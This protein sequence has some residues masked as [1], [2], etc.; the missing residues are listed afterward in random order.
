[1]PTTNQQEPPA[2]PAYGLKRPTFGLSREK[3][4]RVELILAVRGG[5]VITL[6]SELA[7]EVTAE[8]LDALATE[9]AGQIASGQTRTFSD[10]WS[11]TGQKSWVNLGEVVAFTVRQAK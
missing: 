1:M 8:G 7:D 2:G 9:L 4:N 6:Y 11:A 5:G 3:S 10:N